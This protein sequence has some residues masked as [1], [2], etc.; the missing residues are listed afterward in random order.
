[1]P[2]RA[3]IRRLL[4]WLL[5]AAL[6]ALAWAQTYADRNLSIPGAGSDGSKRPIVILSPVTPSGPSPLNITSAHGGPSGAYASDVPGPDIRARNADY[7]TQFT[8]VG[9]VPPGATIRKV[10]WRYTLAS[11]PPGFEARLCWKDAGV[12]WDVSQANAGSTDFFNGRDARQPFQLHYSLRG[13]ARTGEPPIKGE[14]NQV[15]V[16]FDT[17]G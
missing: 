15:I 7:I 12:C 3:F 16:T 4:P 1:M 10:S 14:I 13:T 8:V 5:G 17:P 2:E 11:K 6:P 9:Q